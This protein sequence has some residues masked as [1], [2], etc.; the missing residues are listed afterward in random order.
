VHFDTYFAAEMADLGQLEQDGLVEMTPEAVQVT[1]LG[2]LLLRNI[3]MVFD[4][5]RRR[6]GQQTPL[7]SRTV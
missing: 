2:R 6:Q 3:A 5:Y 7:Y 1:E 4:A